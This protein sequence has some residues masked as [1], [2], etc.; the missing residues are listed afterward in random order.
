MGGQG[1]NIARGLVLGRD[2]GPCLSMPGVAPLLADRLGSE[3]GA[4]LDKQAVTELWYHK[5]TNSCNRY[6][7]L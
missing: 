1:L 4:A 3:E 2:C 7:A 5:K 6:G